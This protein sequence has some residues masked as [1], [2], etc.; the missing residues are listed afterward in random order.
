MNDAKYDGEFPTEFSLAL[1]SFDK[2]HQIKFKRNSNHNHNAKIHTVKDGVAVEVEIK[3]KRVSY[4]TF[5]F[6]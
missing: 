6:N 4:L 3:E 1:S 2:D 5:N